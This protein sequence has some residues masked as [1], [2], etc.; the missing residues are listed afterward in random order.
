MNCEVRLRKELKPY[1]DSNLKVFDVSC[2]SDCLSYSA[3]HVLSRRCYGKQRCKVL[4]NN[5]HFGSPCLPGVK[6]YLSVFYA[7]GKDTPSASLLE[8]LPPGEAVVV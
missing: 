7:C 8:I 5:H 6:K 3:L 2:L 4:V 1:M